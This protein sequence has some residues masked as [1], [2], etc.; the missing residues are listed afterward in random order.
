MNTQGKL[1]EASSSISLASCVVT[2]S[3]T[4]IVAMRGVLGRPISVNSYR[5]VSV[6][7]RCNDMAVSSRKQNMSVGLSIR[8]C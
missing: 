8:L 6:H 5:D 7:G 3:Y 1:N 2:G 4:K